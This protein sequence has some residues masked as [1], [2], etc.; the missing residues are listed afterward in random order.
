MKILAFAGSN[1]KQSINKKLVTWV[2][3]HFSSADVQILDLNDFEMPIFSI[4][5][6]RENGIPV[7]AQTFADAIGQADLL[8]ISLAEHN[9]A[10]TAAF[11]N[12]FDWISRIPEQSVFQDKP[13]F[14]MATSPGGRGGRSVLDIATDRFPRNGG[15]VLATFS[16]PSFK[17]NF[18]EGTGITEPAFKAELLEKIEAVKA[19]WK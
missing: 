4:D 15:K 11:K 13:I 2:A 1:S 3:T 5:R 18:E 7:E 6:Q 10:Y 16:L 12:I 19:N 9:G 14:L 17:Q 8:L